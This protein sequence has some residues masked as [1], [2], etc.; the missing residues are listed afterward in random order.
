MQ[1]ILIIGAKGMLGQELVK[2][3]SNKK[4]EVVAW[5]REN[6]DITDAKQVTEKITKLKPDVILNA[7]A[8]NAV[9][10]CEKDAK[11]YALAKKINGN[12]PGYLAK[13]ASTIGATLVHYS[14]DYVFDGMP[15]IP[16]PAG[17]GGSCGSCSLH[18]GFVPELGF[19]E[20]AIPNPIQKYGKSKLLGE[21]NVIKYAQ[22]YYIIRLSKLF[23][24]PA[25]AKDAKRSFFDVMLEVG[26][27]HKEVKAIDEETDCFT[28]AP[29]LAKRTRDILDLE[30]PFGIYHVTNTG[31]CTW[32]E[33]VVELYKQAKI[34]AKV[35]PVSGDEFSRPAQRPYVSTLLNTKLMP[36]RSWKL[37]LKDYLKNK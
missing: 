10:K 1:K 14:T 6:I 22:K 28:Y 33:A 4:N 34:K 27:K 11:E 13:V 25:T 36:M 31:A 12:A 3:F 17:C 8:Y 26:E 5:D 37:A 23:G 24:K 35:V 2:T 29:D 20:D 16:E 7:A 19:K 30:M 9:D 15:D 18:E 32:Y 21:D